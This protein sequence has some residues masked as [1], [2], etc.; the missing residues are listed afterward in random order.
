M[1]TWADAA[2]EFA[3]AQAENYKS[4]EELHSSNPDR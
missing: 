2:M 3:Q 4:D 1:H